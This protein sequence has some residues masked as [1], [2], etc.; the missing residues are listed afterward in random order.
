MH[1]FMSECPCVCRLCASVCGDQKRT[2]D[3]LRLE[4]QVVA[5]HPVWILGTDLVSSGKTG[6]IPNHST[7]SQYFLKKF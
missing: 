5:S 4:L 7:K 6:S 3:L 2:L 1:V